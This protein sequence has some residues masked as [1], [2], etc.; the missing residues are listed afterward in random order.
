MLGYYYNGDAEPYVRNIPRSM[1]AAYDTYATPGLPVGAICNPGLE[2]LH[3]ALYP[4]ETKYLYFV[5]DVDGHSLFAET[6]AQHEK[7]KATV[8]QNKEAAANG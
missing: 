1:V 6:N 3:A 5:A 4:E 7:N 8:K 2:A